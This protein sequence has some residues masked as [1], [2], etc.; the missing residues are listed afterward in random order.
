M[1]ALLLLM[2]DGGCDVKWTGLVAFMDE[3]M[4]VIRRMLLPTRKK[5]LYKSNRPTVRVNMN[6]S[7][8]VLI[9]VCVCTVLL[10]A[11]RKPRN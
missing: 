11:G 2:G 7:M 3:Y 10:C 4:N 5:P 8:H 6:L 9:C 1:V